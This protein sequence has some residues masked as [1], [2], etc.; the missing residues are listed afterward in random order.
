MKKG[1]VS[2]VLVLVIIT[3][4][5]A[6]G[7]QAVNPVAVD[8]KNDKCAT[9]NM[10]V[11]NNQYATEVVLENGKALKFDDIGCMYKW[12]QENS[13]EKLQAKFVRDYNTKEWVPSEKAT[14]V[15]ETSI[16]TPMAYNVISFQNKSDAESY[17][18]NQKGSVLSYEDLNNHKWEMNK[19]MMKMMKDNKAMNPTN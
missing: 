19:E 17:V 12:L 8:E 2:T 7:K 10:A 13:G 9:C 14:Y 4:L 6:C 16:K 1:F 11:T 3:I 18:K 5:A 15:Y